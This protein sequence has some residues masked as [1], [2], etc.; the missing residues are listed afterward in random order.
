MEKAGVETGRGWGQMLRNEVGGE[1]HM[2]LSS[3]RLIKCICVS[4][5][6]KIM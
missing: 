3:C 5:S 2:S 4:D 6:G 1:T